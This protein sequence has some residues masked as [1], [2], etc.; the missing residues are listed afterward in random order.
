MFGR[1]R[2][3]SASSS[4]APRA[5]PVNPI[6]MGVQFSNDIQREK[7]ESLLTRKQVTQKFVDKNPLINLYIFP[8]IQRMFQN[9]GWENLLDVCAFSYRKP[10]LEFL[11]SV[12]LDHGVL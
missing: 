1:K 5:P 3:K 6:H 7:F 8:Q 2:K 4:R 12:S 9:I 10:T 11:S